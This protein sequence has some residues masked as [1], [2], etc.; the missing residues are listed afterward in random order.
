MTKDFLNDNIGCQ[1]DGDGDRDEEEDVG[2]ALLRGAA[3]EL[4][5]IQASQQA[6]GKKRKQTAV[7]NLSN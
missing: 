6:D 4:G 5:V 7:E 2:P 3:H 1:E